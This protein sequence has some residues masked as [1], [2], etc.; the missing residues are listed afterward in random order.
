MLYNLAVTHQTFALTTFFSNPNIAAE[1][2]GLI[3]TLP[4]FLVLFMFFTEQ[5]Y[6]II[7]VPNKLNFIL[8]SSSVFYL[9]S[10]FPQPALSFGIL[11]KHPLFQI[12]QSS[13]DS[14]KAMIMLSCDAFIYLAL[15]FYL[16]EVF[17]FFI[18]FYLS[19]KKKRF[20]LMNLE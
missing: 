8:R 3:M 17:I 12:F 2:I 15:Y 7:F 20:F 9:I 10:L 16:D 19:H 6:L 1:V 13:F 4:S 18:L 5:K 14:Q 11:S